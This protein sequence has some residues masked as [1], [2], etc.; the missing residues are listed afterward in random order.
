MN[1]AVVNR[2]IEDAARSAGDVG[3]VA[4]YS[5]AW[6]GG[7]GWFVQEMARGIAAAGTPVTLISPEAEPLSREPRHPNLSRILL[8]QGAGGRG[9]KPYRAFLALKRIALTFPLILKGRMKAKTILVTMTDW[10]PVTLL[11]F[12][13]MRLIGA[14][15]VYV[16]HDVR[17]HAYSLPAR[18]R[19]LEKLMI[20]ISYRL[21]HRLV[22]LT[23]TARKEM[24]SYEKIRPDKVT[25]IPHGAYAAEVLTP[26]PGNSIVLVF[27][28]LRRNKN[29]LETIRAF[30]KLPE[31][32]RIRLVIAGEPHVDDLD[33]WRDCEGELRTLGDRVRC[34]VGFVP[35]QR[36][37]ELLSECDALILPYENFTSQSGVAVLA[38]LSGRFVIATNV[39]GIGELIQAGLEAL[40]IER[41]VS[42]VTIAQA[43]TEFEAIT[44]PERRERTER[45]VGRLTDYLSWTRIG[46]EYAEVA[47]AVAAKGG[48]TA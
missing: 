12:L 20:S 5:S 36:V 13:W 48:S 16:V 43:L 44:L 40:T 46:R 42:A 1:K 34:E 19:K 4:I 7:S 15:L 37:N 45:S 17:P 24:I 8:P 2:E 26:L 28:M 31:T 25:V 14:R 41:P 38:A 11:Q 23:E 22:T 21:P 32:S 35:E 18:L 9:P 10:L 27:G 47:R 29:I 39:G 33:Y 3:A 6:R 30:A